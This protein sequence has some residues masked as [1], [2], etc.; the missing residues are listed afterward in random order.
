MNDV[1]ISDECRC[2]VLSIELFVLNIT[3]ILNTQVVE[4]TLLHPKRHH[5]LSPL[6]G[7]VNSLSLI[8]ALDLCSRLFPYPSYFFSVIF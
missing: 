7:L 3:S 8:A 1:E 4:E 6:K 5:R 2:Y